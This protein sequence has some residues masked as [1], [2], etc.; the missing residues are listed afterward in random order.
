MENI[1]PLKK[2]KDCTP[3]SNYGAAKYKS[4][5]YIEKKLKKYVILRLYQVYGPHQKKIDLFLTLSINVLN[6]KHL[7]VQ[8]VNS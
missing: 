3:Q 4:S 2:K 5:K 1:N 7:N 8:M 6:K